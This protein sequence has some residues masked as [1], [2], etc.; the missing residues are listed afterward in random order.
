MV[1]VSDK[2][3]LVIMFMYAVSFGVLTAQF[4]YADVYGITLKDFQGKPIKDL[5]IKISNIQTIS[6]VQSNI[7]QLNGTSVST[8]P[9]GVASAIGDLAITV[10]ELMSGIYIFDIIYHLGVPLIFIVGMV[11]LY[12]ILLARFVFAAIRGVF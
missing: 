10:V 9:L 4:V 3:L 5:F 11:G 6:K 8:N 12:I 1:F 7:G 2:A